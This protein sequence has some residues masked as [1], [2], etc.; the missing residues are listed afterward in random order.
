MLTSAAIKEKLLALG[1][2]G[3]GVIPAVDFDDYI[4]P[5]EK[6]VESFPQSAEFYKG[7]Y[8]MAKVPKEAKSIIVATRKYSQYKVP[9]SLKGRIGKVY[10]FDGRL[11]HSAER[12]AYNKFR[13][14]LSDGG[15]NIIRAPIPA[16][17][18]AVRAGLGFWGDNNFLYTPD[19]S[20]VWIDNWAVDIELEYENPDMD[21]ISAKKLCN[22]NCRK[23]VEACPTGALCGKYSMDMGKCVT[24]ITS[25]ESGGTLSDEVNKNMG[26]WLYGCDACQ[27]A[28]PMNYG[29]LTGTE[30]FPGLSE[31][32]KLLSLESILEM[33]ADTYRETLQ[34]W[35]F[36]ISEDGQWLWKRHALRAMKNGGASA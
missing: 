36:Y 31:I 12:K 29:K 2:S 23:C 7:L 35:F 33:D 5:L 10:M 28:C 14:Y 3:A 15:V 21:A 27:D 16:R 19:G 13:E 20:Y 34:P 18:A 4:P 32:E 6:R 11:E 25:D 17:R 26:Q 9:D 30:N 1:Y 24:R 8:G 22:E